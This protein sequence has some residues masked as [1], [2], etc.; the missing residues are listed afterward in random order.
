MPKTVVID[1]LHLTVRV[2]T[3]LPDADAVR[4]I[5][6]GAEF[7]PQLRRVIRATVRAFPELATCRLSL[8]R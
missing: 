4:Q 7:M 3:D 2:P 8:T 6:L 1:E 5:L